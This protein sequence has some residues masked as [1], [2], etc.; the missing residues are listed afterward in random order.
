MSVSFSESTADTSGGTN[1]SGARFPAAPIENSR[2]TAP[3]EPPKATFASISRMT[4]YLPEWPLS[5]DL[6][7][8][9][10]SL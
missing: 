3:K 9:P 8:Q 5:C 4:A 10:V 1:H 7:F 6:A 2:F